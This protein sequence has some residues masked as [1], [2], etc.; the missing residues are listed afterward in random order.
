MD[1]LNRASLLLQRITYINFLVFSP[2]VRLQ[3][4]DVVG[5][6]KTLSDALGLMTGLQNIQLACAAVHALT[7]LITGST[8][9]PSI[10]L[11]VGRDDE[12]A[13][14]EQNMCII[15]QRNPNLVELELGSAAGPSDSLLQALAAHCPGLLILL[16][17]EENAFT[18]VRVAALATGCPHLAELSLRKCALLTDAPGVELP[19]AAQIQLFRSL[20]GNRKSIANAAREPRMSLQLD[21]PSG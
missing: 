14:Q 2:N 18:D 13:N 9:L 1:V 11:L 20:G 3:F 5:S 16:L 21:R 19:T 15:A 7:G 17:K 12:S 8:V 10:L 6:I 4:N